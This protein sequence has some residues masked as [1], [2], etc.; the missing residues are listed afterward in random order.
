MTWGAPVQS[1]L[2]DQLGDAERGI[3]FGLVRTV[4]LLIGAIGSSVVGIVVTHTGWAIGFSLLASLLGLC[5][6]LI[7]VQIYMR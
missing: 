4:Y 6:L 7:L 2:M 3:G 5:L 1:Q